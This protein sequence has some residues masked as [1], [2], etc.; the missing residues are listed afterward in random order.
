MWYVNSAYF[1]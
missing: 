1:T